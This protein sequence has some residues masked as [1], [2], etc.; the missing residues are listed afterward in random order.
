MA[1]NNHLPDEPTLAERDKLFST[2]SRAQAG[3]GPHDAEFLQLCKRIVPKL[4]RQILRLERELAVR[5]QRKKQ[6]AVT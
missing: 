1:A 3:L 4:Q 5:E 6:Q 2:A